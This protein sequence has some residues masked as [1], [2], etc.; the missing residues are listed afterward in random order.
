MKTIL[1]GII[2]LNISCFDFCTKCKGKRQ[3]FT[4][5]RQKNKFG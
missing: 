3:D 2:A 1:S 4:Q 5:V